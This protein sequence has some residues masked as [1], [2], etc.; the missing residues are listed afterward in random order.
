MMRKVELAVGA[1]SSVLG[2]GCA[3]ILG[4]VGGDVAR[5]ALDV[6]FDCGVNHLDLARSYGYGEA[7]RFVGKW[8]RGKRENVV[9]ASK[10]GIRATWRAALLRPLKPVVRALRPRAGGA[11]AGPVL[12]APAVPNRDPFHERIPLRAADMRSSLDASLKALGTDH[13]DLFFVHEPKEGF[14]HLDELAEAA[15]LLKQEGKIRAWGLAF[16][17][18]DHFML[19]GGL[20]AFDVLQFNASPV[21]EHYGAAVAD[22]GNSPNVLFSPLRQ[23]GG[24]APGD[25]LRKL[26]ADFPNSVVLCSMFDPEHIRANADAAAG[27]G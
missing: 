11:P 16:D 14:A 1:R 18:A 20:G 4:A 3:P 15:Y 13:L 6:A 22:L 17:W 27:G 12:A 9:L 5:R 19:A 8:L 10:F 23:R 2:F 24:L 7:E 21:A 26:W 25:A